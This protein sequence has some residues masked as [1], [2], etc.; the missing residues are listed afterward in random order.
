M[1][2]K[3]EGYRLKVVCKPL[4]AVVP[5]PALDWMRQK[6][7]VVCRNTFIFTNRHSPSPIKG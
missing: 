7:T 1:V 4:Q 6:T 3:S 5:A 2:R